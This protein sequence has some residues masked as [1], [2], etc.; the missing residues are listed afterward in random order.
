MMLFFSN[1]ISVIVVI[2]EMCIVSYTNRLIVAAIEP[3]RFFL[4][5]FP[6]P[7]F[8]L[9]TRC[10]ASSTSTLVV[11]HIAAG[12][13]FKVTPL[14]ARLGEVVDNGGRRGRNGWIGGWEESR[15]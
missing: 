9:H 14:A 15:R 5:D 7:V 4:Q 13:E 3:L 2:T 11:G 1:L 6:L 12:P 10:R 8:W